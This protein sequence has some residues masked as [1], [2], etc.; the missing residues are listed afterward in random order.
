MIILVIAK[1]MRGKKR[2]LEERLLKE[3]GIEQKIRMNK[4]LPNSSEGY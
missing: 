1:L 3:R 2:N 4:Q